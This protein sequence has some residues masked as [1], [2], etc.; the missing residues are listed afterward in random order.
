[1]ARPE[2]AARDR[3]QWV[4]SVEKLASWFRYKTPRALE[5]LKFEGAEGRATFD[6]LRPRL[7]TVRHAAYLLRIFSYFCIRV[8]NLVCL[9]N[10]FF[11]RIDPFE[12]VPSGSFGVSQLR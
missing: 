1:L 9:G 12:T 10:E 5:S 4:Y 2:A 6:D 11:N 7:P 8:Q 3:Q